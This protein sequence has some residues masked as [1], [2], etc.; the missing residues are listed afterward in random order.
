MTAFL[1]LR[2]KTKVP[3]QV[4]FLAR[5]ICR[6]AGYDPDQLVIGFDREKDFDYLH[7]GL[8]PVDIKKLKPI[9]MKFIN[10]AEK[11]ITQEGSDSPET[12]AY[13]AWSKRAHTA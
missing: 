5:E 4:E 7:I 13:Y 9:F 12:S 11:I 3:K 2:R 8:A 10:E 6:R 1:S